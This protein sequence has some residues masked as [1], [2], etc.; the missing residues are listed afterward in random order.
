M[1]WIFSTL[2]HKI[3]RNNLFISYQRQVGTNWTSKGVTTN[4]LSYF[5]LFASYPVRPSKITNCSLQKN[6]ALA[7]FT[8]RTG[9]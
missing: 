5:K 4:D 1:K 2:L 6:I 9:W 3:E 7:M 8:L